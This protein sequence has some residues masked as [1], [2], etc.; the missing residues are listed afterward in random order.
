VRWKRAELCDSCAS[1]FSD[2]NIYTYVYIYLIATYSYRGDS[3][4]WVSKFVSA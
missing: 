2:V 4:I 1:S 3:L